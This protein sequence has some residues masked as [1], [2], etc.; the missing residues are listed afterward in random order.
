MSNT[1]Q[2]RSA[3]ALPANVRATL[4]ASNLPIE[5]AT[6]IADLCEQRSEIVPTARALA[7]AVLAYD[8]AIHSCANDPEKMSSFCSAEG[9]DLDTLYFNMVN[10]ARTL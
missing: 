7:D 10:A 5:V 4:E 3:A 8:T 9:D 2:S 6:A 1:A